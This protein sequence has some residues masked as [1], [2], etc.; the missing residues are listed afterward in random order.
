MVGN[1]DQEDD[2]SRN[3]DSADVTYDS[4]P[5]M[6]ADRLPEEA[7]ECYLQQPGYRYRIVK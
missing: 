7:K 5:R 3:I 6:I 2:L 1:K 4:G